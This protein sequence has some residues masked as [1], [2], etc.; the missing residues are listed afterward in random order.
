[1]SSAT[2][3]TNHGEIELELFEDDAPKTVENFLKLSRD[4]YYDGLVFHRVIEDF[5]IQ[6][7]GFEPGMT[8]K[9]T[10]DPIKNESDNGLSNVRGTLHSSLFTFPF[11][12]LT[13]RPSR[14]SP[15]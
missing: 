1:M 9:K 6:G 14:A 15:T 7:G 2:M 4:G 8:Q 10:R 11:S 12:L 5:M 3:Q 13:C